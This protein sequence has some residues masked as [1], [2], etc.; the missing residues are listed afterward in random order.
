MIQFYAGPEAIVSVGLL[1]FE[2]LRKWDRHSCLSLCP[3]V[4]LLKP[5]CLEALTQ[6]SNTTNGSWWFLQI[7]PTHNGHTR[8]MN[9]TN[10]SWWIVQILPIQRVHV[11]WI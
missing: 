11:G 2:C 4:G 3:L 9:P 10:G 8:V 7:Q 1:K 6:E 5:E